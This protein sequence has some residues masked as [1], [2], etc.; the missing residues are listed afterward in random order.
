MASDST[1]RLLVLD[2][3]PDVAFTMCTIAEGV[4]FTADHTSDVEEFLEKVVAWE[5]THVAIDLQMPGRDGIEVLHTLARM[6]CGAAVIIVSGLGGRIVNSA[7]RV[8]AENGLHL[9]GTLSKPYTRFALRELLTSVMPDVPARKPSSPNEGPCS[10]TEQEVADAL[11]ERAFIAHFQPKILCGNHD[12]VGF[13]CLARWFRD[14]GSAVPPDTF[15]KLVEQTGQIHELTR[16]VYDFALANFPRPA[17][18]D[19]LSIAL[20]L[21]PV[22]LNDTTF[23]QWLI[24]KCREYEVA[25]SRVILEVTETASPDNPL[26][27]LENLTQFR[28]QGFHLAIDDFG[29]GYS[30]LV[31]LAR[32]PFSELKI[33][34]SFVQSAASS[35][36]SRKIIIALVS[37]GKSLGLD[38]S[39]EG[40]EDAWALNFLREIGCDKAQGYFI[41]RPMDGAAA[42][43][44]TRFPAEDRP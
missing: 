42:S 5:P 3:E 28:I 11:R 7:A 24:S 35:K 23:P 17:K 18:R 37:L 32:L 43:R 13:E 34:R 20:N 4:S 27:L 15:I 19:D 22:N 14:D 26:A 21:S 44:W 29:V 41:A 31:Q 12:L 40:V 38:V 8:A 39:A 6:H 2:D 1:R 30:S 9:I 33:D 25:P 16:Q 36:E 10:V